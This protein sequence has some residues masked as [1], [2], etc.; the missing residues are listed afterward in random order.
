[1]EVVERSGLFRQKVDSCFLEVEIRR[2]E[3]EFSE[4]RFFGT[5]LFRDG[6]TAVTISPVDRWTLELPAVDNPWLVTTSASDIA[7][8][9]ASEF[10]DAI[11]GLEF[12]E[13]G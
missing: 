8:I 7:G 9:D 5:Q 1:M 4:R 2:H 6:S 3:S 11:L 13:A 12:M 10:A